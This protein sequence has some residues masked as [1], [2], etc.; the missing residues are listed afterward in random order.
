M[1]ANNIALKHST[2][3]K[4]EKVYVTY[5][6][7][8]TKRSPVDI[9]QFLIKK[10]LPHYSPWQFLYTCKGL[11]SWSSLE[12]RQPIELMHAVSRGSPTSSLLAITN[13]WHPAIT[14]HAW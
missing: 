10:Q 4:E 1:H 13:E 12:K 8:V 3:S 5:R 6:A 11:A 14:R 9:D 7:K 2:K